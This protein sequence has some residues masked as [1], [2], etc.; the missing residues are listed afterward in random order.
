MDDVYMYHPSENV[1][2]LNEIPVPIG[3]GKV[4][5]LNKIPVPMGTG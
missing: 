4:F 5:I 3:T 1:S 2:N